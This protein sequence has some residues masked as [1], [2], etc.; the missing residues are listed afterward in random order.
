MKHDWKTV[1]GTGVEVTEWC[2][3]CGTARKRCPYDP[4]STVYFV[5]GTK[6]GGLVEP[7]CKHVDGPEIPRQRH[8]RTSATT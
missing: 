3:N 7:R 6:E 4:I 2:V 5:V 1:I 8:T